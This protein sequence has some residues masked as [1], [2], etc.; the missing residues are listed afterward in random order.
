VPDPGEELHGIQD[1]MYD[2][3]LINESVLD[4]I[5]KLS[6]TLEDL[7]PSSHFWDVENFDGKEFLV[8]TCQE[9]ID[10][11]VELAR[12]KKTTG[13]TYKEYSDWIKNNPSLLGRGLKD[14]PLD[15]EY[16][17][18]KKL[19]AEFLGKQLDSWYKV[20]AAIV[21][22]N[23]QVTSK[24]IST[25][26]GSGVDPYDG[27]DTSQFTPGDKMMHMMEILI[28]SLKKFVEN[29]LQG[30]QDQDGNP[31][32]KSETYVQ[33]HVQEH[34]NGIL[35][36]NGV[37]S[38]KIHAD[39]FLE[40]MGEGGLVDVIKYNWKN[41]FKEIFDGN[42][43]VLNHLTE[44]KQIRDPVF[45]FRRKSPDEKEILVKNIEAY[46][47]EILWYIRKYAGR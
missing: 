36:N 37:Y 38:E 11:Y 44:I 35:K 27:T 31:W 17:K 26:Y 32:W 9:K 6:L 15:D 45:H 23:Q 40:Y 22:K 25:K 1:D 21:A 20:D 16:A 41:F 3:E 13:K 2:L 34:T 7:D 8:W 12:Q 39:L 28:P 19:F 46:T 10:S 42:K 5:G 30:Q 47:S 4:E 18:T 33:K 24:K 14:M 29:V 43:N